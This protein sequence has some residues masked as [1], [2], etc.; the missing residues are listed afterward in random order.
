[1]SSQ[2]ELTGPE[3]RF[4][5]RVVRK[6]LTMVGKEAARATARG[7]KFVASR[8][9]EGDF[10]ECG[11]WRGGNSMIA[12]KLFSTYA[13]DRTVH[14]FDTFAGMTEPEEIDRTRRSGDSA[15][16]KFERVKAKDHVDWCYASLDEVRGNF[17]AFE[18]DLTNVRFVKG[19]VL[20]TLQD[21]AN[22]PEKIAMLRLDTDWYQSTKL[23]LEVLYP[24]L[25]PNGIIIIDDYYSWAGSHKAVDEYFEKHGKRPFFTRL[26]NGGC[27]GMK[28]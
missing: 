3:A 2:F 5:R 17:E 1:M 27:I 24:R 16:E 19:D 20:D 4:V 23:E 7:A 12:H 9:I 8:G 11:V 18:M 28:P 21:P 26:A 6:E 10:V 22:L 13:P 14:L 15:L 25:E